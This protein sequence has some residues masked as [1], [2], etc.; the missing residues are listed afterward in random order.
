MLY[1]IYQAHAAMSQPMRRLSRGFA[2]MMHAM[3]GMR[4]NSL[5]LRNITATLDL[6]ADAEI[7]HVRPPFGIDS[8]RV[9]NRMVAVSEEVAAASPFCSLLHFRKDM[10]LEDGDAQPRLLIMAPM[11]GHF[12]TL[13]RGTVRTALSDYDVY[14][15]DWHNARDVPLAAGR[16]GLDE[17]VGELRRQMSHDGGGFHVLAVCQPAVPALAAVA[18]MAA[19]EDPAEPRSVTLM[20]GP[21]DTSVAP[22]DV[23]KLASEHDLDWFDRNL[24]TRVPWRFKGA[25]RRVYPGFL[26]LTAFISMNVERHA[27]KHWDH[28]E[29]LI[30]GNGES[31]A[32][33]RAFYNEYLSVMDMPAEFYLETLDRVFIRQD[34]ARGDFK[35]D[36]R[37][38]DLARIRKP[39][40]LTVEGALDDICSLGQTSAALQLCS[41]IPD[42]RKWGYVQEGVG[43]YGVFSGRR[44]Q[45][46]I[47]PQMQRLIA[48]NERA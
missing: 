30:R 3:P 31:I 2:G 10:D 14:I 9:G 13:L 42:A 45:T 5:L 21:V 24:V 48:A 12:S 27:H 22:T 29:N 4:D 26:Q 17:F 34:L 28:F 7:T 18:L 11:S 43:H 1:D 44:W 25:F 40:L 41:G 16:F 20:A 46:G 47:Y 8:V 36:G 37:R 35:V 33:H 38:V 23:D 15:T 19:D 6:M 32:A 39:G